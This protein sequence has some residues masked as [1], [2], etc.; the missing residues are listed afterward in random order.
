MLPKQSLPI[1]EL[2]VPSTKKKVKFRPFTVREEKVLL[3]ALEVGDENVMLNAGIGVI[4]ACVPD[5][6][7][8]NKL[9]LFDAEYILT[10]IRTKSVEESVTLDMPCDE[11]EEHQK[12]R[13][14]INLDA[15]NVVYPEGHQTNIPLYDDVGIVMKYPTIGDIVELDKL[16]GVELVSAC[17][18]YIY[19]KDEIFKSEEQT[20]EELADFIDNLTKPQFAKIEDLFFKRMPYFEINVDYTCRD[21]GK[22]HQKHFRGFSSFFG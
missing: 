22:K 18:D 12:S 7:D 6:G 3:Q 20:A 4:S 9:T 21:C 5:I 8:V 11:S 1:F 14:M 13:I 19:T 17:I 2:V 15:L 10:A 16:S